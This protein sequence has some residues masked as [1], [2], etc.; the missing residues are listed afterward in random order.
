MSAILPEPVDNEDIIVS[1]Q[2]IKIKKTKSKK[3]TNRTTFWVMIGIVIFAV[4]CLLAAFSY[5]Y[6]HNKSQDTTRKQD[7]SYISSE[8]NTYHELNR[9]YPTLEQINSTTFAAFSTNLDRSKFTVPDSSSTILVAYPSDS[10]YAYQP[11]PSNCNNVTISCTGY[12]L[13]A[14]LNDGSEYTVSSDNTN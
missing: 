12:K 5:D 1:S 6:V 10:N 13:I 11:I 7:L 4:I 3:T 8:I 9:I 2:P 14:V